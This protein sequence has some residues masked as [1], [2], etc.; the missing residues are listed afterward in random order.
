LVDEDR[1]K[2]VVFKNVELNNI[3]A[4]G[5]VWILVAY[6]ICDVDYVMPIYG[7]CGQIMIKYYVDWYDYT[8]VQVYFSMH[9]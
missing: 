2:Y 6:S 7:L 3:W 8:L 4:I 1:G 5:C 9:A